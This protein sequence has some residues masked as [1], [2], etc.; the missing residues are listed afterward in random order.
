MVGC[1]LR[2]RTVAAADALAALDRIRATVREV[3]T[4]SSILRPVRQLTPTN[5]AHTFTIHDPRDSLHDGLSETPTSMTPSS[6]VEP[7]V[8]STMSLPSAVT[9]NVSGVASTI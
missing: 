2:H 9:G 1:R 8:K 5:I 6:I 7:G 3:S 4:Y